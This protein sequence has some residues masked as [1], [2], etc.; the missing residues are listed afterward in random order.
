MVLFT[1]FG[2]ESKKRHLFIEMPGASNLLFEILTN[3]E[4]PY[5]QV[6]RKLYYQ[7][8]LMD[9]LLEDIDRLNKELDEMLILLREDNKK[10]QTFRI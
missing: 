2:D 1:D 4:Y 6:S 8:L 5:D 7:S 10:M 3:P 9:K